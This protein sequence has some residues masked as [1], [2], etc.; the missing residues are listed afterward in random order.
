MYSYLFIQKENSVYILYSILSVIVLEQEHYSFQVVPHGSHPKANLAFI[1]RSFFVLSKRFIPV[2]SCYI[3]K[4]VFIMQ[5]SFLYIHE[6]LRTCILFLRLL[7]RPR[8]EDH[9]YNKPASKSPSMII[10][11]SMPISG[12]RMPSLTTAMP[13]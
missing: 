5:P 10:G 4:A 9:N 11:V 2:R 1:A 13:R 8:L 12:S 7:F 3:K 6:Y